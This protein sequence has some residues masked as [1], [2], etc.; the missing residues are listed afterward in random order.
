MV[1]C[2]ATSNHPNDPL[3]GETRPATVGA[4]THVP[5]PSVSIRPN[6]W[7]N[8]A[9]IALRAEARASAAHR[10]GLDTGNLADALEGETLESMVAV[11]AVRHSFHHLYVDWYPLL[12]LSS[13]GDEEQVPQLATT[14]VP[15]DAAELSSWKNRFKEIVID[16]NEIVHRAQHNQSVVAHPLGTNTS[17][18]DARFTSERATEAVDAMLDFYQRVIGQPSEALGPWAESNGHVLDHFLTLRMKYRLAPPGETVGE[19]RPP[20]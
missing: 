14:D 20:S 5:R 16:R 18:L 19:A 2:M 7:H 6:L 4:K 12:G 1:F 13:E 3:P 15:A 17:A 10:F 9:R 11:S 8:W